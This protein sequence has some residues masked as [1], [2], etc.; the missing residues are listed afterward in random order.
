MTRQVR[1]CCLSDI[2]LPGNLAV[3]CFGDFAAKDGAVIGVGTDAGLLQLLLIFF[4]NL[5][6][7]WWKGILRKAPL[8]LCSILDLT[9]GIP[10]EPLVASSA[11]LTNRLFACSAS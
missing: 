4:N 5:I 9:P 6:S 1:Q 10:A 2:G 3:N 8:N 7:Q 11:A